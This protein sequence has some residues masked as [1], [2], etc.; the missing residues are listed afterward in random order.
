[1]SYQT[2]W[3]ENKEW[4]KNGIAH[5]KGRIKQEDLPVDELNRLKGKLDGFMTILSKVN[6]SD[7]VYKLCSHP[8]IFMDEDVMYCIDCQRDFLELNMSKVS[9]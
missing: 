1:M 9:L 3:D 4:I 7:R 6:E 2:A 8:N 5:L